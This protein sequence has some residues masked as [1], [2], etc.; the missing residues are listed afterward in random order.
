V[1]GLHGGTA[2]R[3]IDGYDTGGKHYDPVVREQTTCEDA[4]TW[5]EF[6]ETRLL[7]EYRSSG[8]RKRSTDRWSAC[9]RK[10]IYQTSCSTRSVRSANRCFVVGT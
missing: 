4:V 9:S 3:W 8:P 10:R 6:V 1:L 5:G 2:K 7:S